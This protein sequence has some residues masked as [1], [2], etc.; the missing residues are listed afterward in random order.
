M[1]QCEEA[2]KPGKFNESSEVPVGDTKR[3]AVS[4]QQN[5]SINSTEHHSLDNQFLEHMNMESSSIRQ[6]SGETDF[7]SQQI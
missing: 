7:R 3:E 4:N 6:F 2:G 1:L 5:L